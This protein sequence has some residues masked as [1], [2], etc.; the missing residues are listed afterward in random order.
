MKKLLFV[1]VMASLVLAACG[2]GSPAATDAPASNAPVEI[3]VWG[4]QAPAFN[5]AN[6][7]MFDDFMAANS[8]ASRAAKVAL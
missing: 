7:K 3:R 8:A 1:F 2:G 5:E 4:H 6:Q